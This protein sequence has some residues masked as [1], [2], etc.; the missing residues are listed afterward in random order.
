MGLLSCFTAEHFKVAHPGYT[1][2]SGHSAGDLEDAS[3]GL[4]GD[5]FRFDW[6]WLESFDYISVMHE[7]I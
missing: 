1:T 2:G 7:A 3:Q 6:W 5:K 4:F